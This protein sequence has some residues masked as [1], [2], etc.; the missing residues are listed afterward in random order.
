MNLLNPHGFQRAAPARL[1]AVAVLSISL[2]APLSPLLRAHWPAE[3]TA[4]QRPP[5]G[6]GAERDFNTLT[7]L[8]LRLPYDFDYLDEDVL[9][10]AALHRV[11]LESAITGD[12]L[13]VRVNSQPGENA[14][15]LRVA[16]TPANP[17]EGVERPSDPAGA[18][19]LVAYRPFA[20]EW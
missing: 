16:D 3:L 7:D 2:V 18:P 11:F 6:E 20:F 1:A 4:H 12:V 5:R 13:E 15:E 17:S 14:L 19:R 9:A 10:Q 8:L